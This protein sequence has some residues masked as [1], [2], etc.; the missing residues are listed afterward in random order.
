MSHA[1]APSQSPSTPPPPDSAGA[2]ESPH[3]H[4]AIL[5]MFLAGGAGMALTSTTGWAPDW[6]GFVIGFAGAFGG[7][8]FW[9]CRRG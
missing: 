5:A 2:L 9:R 8:D 1:I 6:A 3:D 4:D 7:A